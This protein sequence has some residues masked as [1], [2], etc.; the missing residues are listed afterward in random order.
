[1]KNNIYSSQELTTKHSVEIINNFQSKIEKCYSP[2]TFKYI[3][4]GNV[5]SFIVDIF[6]PINNKDC[7]R[8]SIYL[9]E[10]DDVID[11]KLILNDFA[12]TSKDFVKS[13]KGYVKTQ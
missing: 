5:L 9:N 4:V 3:P 8:F 7:Y 13:F 11:E 2:S 1:M 10:D 12:V 6:R